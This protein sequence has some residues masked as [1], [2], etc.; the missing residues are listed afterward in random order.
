MSRA[1][2]NL[3]NH[4]HNQIQI[5]IQPLPHGVGITQLLQ[6]TPGSAGYD[7]AAAIASSESRTIAPGAR[8]LVPCGL[9]IAMPHGVEAQI[10][11][12]SG[13]ALSHGV[14]VL[15]SPGTIDSDYLGEIKV[16]LVNHGSEPFPIHRGDRIAQLVFAQ[17]LQPKITV[18]YKVAQTAQADQAAQATQAAQAAA[19]G[20][21]RR[22]ANGFGSTGITTNGEY[23]I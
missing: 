14:T 17:I 21:N 22:S 10:R 9:A 1:E 20:A 2:T 18:S 23:C 13:L 8:L 19:G 16:L 7:L 6:A 4:I 12:R 3:Q 5:Q 11:P 15:N